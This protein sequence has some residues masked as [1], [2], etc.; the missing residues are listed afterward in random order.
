MPQ[1][2][3]APPHL[4]LI[5]CSEPDDPILLEDGGIFIKGSIYG[6][7]LLFLLLTLLL[8]ECWVEGYKESLIHG[9]DG[10]CIKE[11]SANTKY[12]NSAKLVST[13]LLP[14][15]VLLHQYLCLCCTLQ[16]S[17]RSVWKPRPISIWDPRGSHH[18]TLRP[19]TS[20]TSGPLFSVERIQG[21][22]SRSGTLWD[23]LVP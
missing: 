20:S 3:Q 5:S 15:L 17:L 11:W 7:A 10:Q 1:Q 4:W 2:Y 18:P 16:S 14:F 13:Q 21:E 19:L 22:D 23:A 8:I 12:P 6:G 9:N